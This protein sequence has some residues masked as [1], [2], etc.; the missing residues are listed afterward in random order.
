MVCHGFGEFRLNLELAEFALSGGVE[1]DEDLLEEGVELS[2]LGSDH[3]WEVGM[4]VLVAVVDVVDLTE[5]VLGHLSLS[6][7]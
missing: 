2:R 7:S 5:S 4:G 6:H 3:A 1:V